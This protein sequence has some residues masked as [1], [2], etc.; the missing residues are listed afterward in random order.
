MFYRS[1]RALHAAAA[2]LKDPNSTKCAPARF[3]LAT[4][5]TTK[6]FFDIIHVVNWLPKGWMWG[7][8]LQTSHAAGIA[9]LSGVLGLVIHFRAKQLLPR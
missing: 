4:L 1:I 6:M 7:S 5:T 8:S 3:T 9:T 2:K